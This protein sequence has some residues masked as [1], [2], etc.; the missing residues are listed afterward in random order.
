ML[1]SKLVITCNIEERQHKAVDREKVNFVPS[2]NIVQASKE[3]GL[4][5]GLVSFRF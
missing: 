5:N 1:I 2:A 4:F 3:Y